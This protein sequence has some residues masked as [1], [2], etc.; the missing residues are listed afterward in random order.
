M[1]RPLERRVFP[2]T[3]LDGAHPVVGGE[4][5]LAGAHAWERVERIRRQR[6]GAVLHR[7]THVPCIGAAPTELEGRELRRVERDFRRIE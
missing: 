2:V 4:V 5:D 3:C 1:H 7:G 6:R